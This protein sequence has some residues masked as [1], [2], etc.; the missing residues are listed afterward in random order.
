MPDPI[1]TPETVTLYDCGPVITPEQK[2]RFWNLRVE[3]R[4]GWWIG[5]GIVVGLSAWLALI[6]WWAA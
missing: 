3:P 2:R 6:A 1:R 4:P 5:V